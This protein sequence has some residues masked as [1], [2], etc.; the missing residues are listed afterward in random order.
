MTAF[1]RSLDMDEAMRHLTQLVRYDRYQASAGIDAA[2]EFVAT[3]AE[4]VGLVDVEVLRL[5][6]DG[7]TTWWTFTAPT[8][9]TPRTAM[10]SLPGDSAALNVLTLVRYPEHSYGLAANSAPTGPL[11]L[12]TPLVELGE[13]GWPPGALVLMESAAALTPATLHEL[14]RRGAAGFA[15][16]T[17]PSRHGEF[18]LNPALSADVWREPGQVGRVELPPGCGLFGFSVDD[19]RMARLREAHRAGESTVVTVEVDTRPGTMPV[20]VARTLSGGDQE[21]LLTAHLCHP[22]PGANDNASGVAAA[23]AVGRALAGRSLRRAVRFVWGPEFVGLAGY[24]RTCVEPSSGGARAPRPMMAVNLDMV[25]EDQRL[26]GGPLI[27]EHSP[28]HLPHFINAVADAC[29]RVLPQA[30]RSYSGA[31]GCDVWAWRATPFVGASDH[32]LLADRATGCPAVQIGHWP[33]RFNHSSADTVDKVDPQELRRVTAVTAA[34]LAT[35]C[36]ADADQAAELTVLMTRW[37]AARMLESLSQHGLL[38]SRPRPGWVVPDAD[39]YCAHRIGRRCD[40]GQGA[41]TALGA[42][43]APPDLLA[44]QHDWLDGLCTHLTGEPRGAPPTSASEP[45]RS[46][47]TTLVRTWPGPFNLRGLLAACRPDDRQWME[48][49]LTR[50]RGRCYATAMALAQSIDGQSTPERVITNAAFDSELAIEVRFG[51]RFLDA[52]LRARWVTWTPAPTR[53]AAQ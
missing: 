39:C 36:T 13:S 30:T 20:V 29:V 40:F 22:A 47:E 2:A 38:D 21:C 11:P 4:R 33:D 12:R 53:T 7:H 49:E 44:R 24:L 45:P 3:A 28:Q 18:Q 14:R 9:W 31:V 34:M 23:L 15:V 52:M 48:R 26:C 37:T 50:N 6:A 51:L 35:V 43:G 5:P 25:G 19:A 32:A 27:I 17:A 16:V 1:Y 42:L 8:A 41:L 10:L 46:L